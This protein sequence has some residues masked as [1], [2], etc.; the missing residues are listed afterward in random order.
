MKY[1]KYKIFKTTINLRTI[2]KNQDIFCFN[3]KMYIILKICKKKNFR[4]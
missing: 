4:K 2:E 3:T 1:M